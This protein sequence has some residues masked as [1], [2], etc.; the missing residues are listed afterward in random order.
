M[1]QGYCTQ[2]DEEICIVETWV[3]Y[4][5]CKAIEMGYSLVNVFEVG[6]MK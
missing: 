4:E 3:V 2:T 5:V 1:N 6:I